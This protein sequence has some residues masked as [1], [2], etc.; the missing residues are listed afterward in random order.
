[1]ARGANCRHMT[2]GGIKRAAIQV[3]TLI[4]ASAAAHFIIQFLSA[5]QHLCIT[6][7]GAFFSVTTF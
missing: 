5:T 4:V 7:S 1:M 3:K 6:Q 2:F